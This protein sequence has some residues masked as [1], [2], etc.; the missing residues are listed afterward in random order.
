MDIGQKVKSARERKGISQETLASRVGISQASID[1]IERGVTKHSR[2]LLSILHQLDM[3]LT[4]LEGLYKERNTPPPP[5]VVE[6]ASQPG[7][8][9]PVYSAIECRDG[10]VRRSPEP[11]DVTKRPPPLD[12]VKDGY[13]LIATGE[14]MNPVVKSGEVLIVHPYLAPRS[15]DLVVV[16]SAGAD[17]TRV[18]IREYVTHSPQ[19]WSLRCYQPKESIITVSRDD[20]PKCHVV[21]ARYCR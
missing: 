14:G 4:D 8:T 17:E 7:A 12:L 2:H 11:L 5:S 9:I 1:K 21:V 20:W 13:G 3:P 15:G 19:E 10:S 6:G 16:Y 18:L